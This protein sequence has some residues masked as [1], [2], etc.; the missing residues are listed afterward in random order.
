M[1]D[2]SYSSTTFDRLRFGEL[3]ASSSESVLV[4]A[5]RS[6]DVLPSSAFVSRLGATFLPESG[7][8]AWRFFAVFSDVSPAAG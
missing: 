3:T 4:S 1:F 6:S 2:L 5:A 7:A 8:L